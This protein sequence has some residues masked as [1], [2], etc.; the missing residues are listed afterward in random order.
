MGKR[1]PTWC[2]VPWSF[3]QW[4]RKTS[5]RTKTPSN[6]AHGGWMW[7]DK[8]VPD[9]L[10]ATFTASSTKNRPEVGTA[11]EEMKTQD[12]YCKKGLSILLLKPACILNVRTHRQEVSVNFGHLAWGLFLL[13]YLLYI[14]YSKL[15]LLQWRCVADGLWNIYR[16]TWIFRRVS[17][18]AGVA[19]ARQIVRYHHGKRQRIL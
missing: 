2:P 15:Y 11:H 7:Q 6:P 14:I 4:L 5:Q 18:T 13:L 9:T 17:R 12:L 1:R 3:C 19:F 10:N 8:S 16:L